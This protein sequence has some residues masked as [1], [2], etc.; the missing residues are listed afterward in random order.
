MRMRRATRSAG[1]THVKGRHN[2]AYAS[3]GS[4]SNTP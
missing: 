1:M 2:G 3:N 4:L